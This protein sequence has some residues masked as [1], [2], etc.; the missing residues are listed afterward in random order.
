VTDPLETQ[1]V[2]A[3]RRHEEVVRRLHGE[4]RAWHEGR[5]DWV[6]QWAIRKP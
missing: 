5:G 6:R 4:C 1:N 3:D 2:A